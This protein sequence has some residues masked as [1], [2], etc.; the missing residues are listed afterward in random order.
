MSTALIQADHQWQLA[1]RVDTNVMLDRISA[2][3]PVHGI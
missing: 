3:S 2:G 1:A